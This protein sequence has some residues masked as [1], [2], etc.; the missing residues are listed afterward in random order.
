MRIIN[1]DDDI[2]TARRIRESKIIVKS[3]EERI[4]R[5]V[6]A[7]PATISVTALT[8]A[9]FGVKNMALVGYVRTSLRRLAVSAA[10]EV[11]VFCGDAG[12]LDREAKW[13]TRPKGWS[14]EWE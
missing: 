2:A 7:Y 14:P 6:P 8:V 9:A 11:I 13:T 10:Q 4:L 1:N 12:W 5:H 3:A